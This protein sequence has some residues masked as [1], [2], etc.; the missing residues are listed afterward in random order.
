MARSVFISAGHSDQ[1]P[2]A[3]SSKSGTERIE[4]DEVWEISELTKKYLESHSNIKVYR[5]K[6]TDRWFKA[7]D[8]ANAANVDLFVEF[9]ENAGGGDGAEV[10]IHNKGNQY[11]A[12]AFKKQFL[13]FGQNWRRTIIDPDFVAVRDTKC[14]ACIVELCFVDS[15]DICIMDSTTE[16]KRLAKYMARAIADL[17]DVKLKEESSGGTS[18]KPHEKPTT[19]NRIKEDGIWGRSTTLA[20]QKK[21]NVSARDGILSNQ[22]KGNLNECILSSAIDMDSWHFISKVSSIGS[23]TVKAIQRKVGAPADGVFGPGSIKALQRFLHVKTDG[24]MGRNTVKA[25]QKW[26]NS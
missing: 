15:K 23:S 17:L 9:H 5:D 25:W 26:L 10:I 18:N 7:V 8:R 12:D 4:R 22:Y 2:G 13:A 14:P 16:K 6:W 24:I 3:V 11:I 21:L 1:D 20:T 19:Q